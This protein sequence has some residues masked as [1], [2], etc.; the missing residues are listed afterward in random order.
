MMQLSQGSSNLTDITLASDDLCK[1]FQTG[2]CK[3]GGSCKKRHVSENCLKADCRRKSCLQR[4]PKQC[5]YFSQSGF[6][7][8]GENCSYKHTTSSNFDDHNLQIQALEVRISDLCKAIKVLEE[9]MLE[10]KN[11]NQCERCDYKANSSTSLKT[12]MSK[13]HKNLVPLA[14]EN[15]RVAP[16]DDT[17]N[18]S[19]PGCERE[20]LFPSSISPLSVADENPTMC[21]WC[22][23][24]FKTSSNSEMRKHVEAAHTITSDFVYPKSNVKIVCPSSPTSPESV[25][26]GKEFFMDHTFAMHE[27]NI[28][29]TGFDCDHCHT[30][31]PGGEWLED[32]H[33]RL[34]TFPCSGSP[35]CS[36]KSLS[37]S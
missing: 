32:I 22:Y 28:H 15:E 13:K 30:F 7:R 3:F 19:V 16:P 10:L 33:M 23:C 37:T 34:C 17:L 5:K 36:C 14:P 29:K 26:C 4:H 2:Y 25:S 24:T 9:E 11:A 31:V 8:F 18:L 12:H 21:E 27:Y 1:H 6:C 35:K 20:E